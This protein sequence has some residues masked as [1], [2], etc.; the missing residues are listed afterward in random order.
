MRRSKLR[1]LA[2]VSAA[3]ASLSLWPAAP[4]RAGSAVFDGDAAAIGTQGDNVTFSSAANWTTDGNVDTAPNLTTTAPFD[5]LTFGGGTAGAIIDLGGN[6]GANS[7][8]FNR[9]YTLGLAATGN[10]LSLST[11]NVSVTGGNTGTINAI[12]AGTAGLNLSGGG[13]LTLNRSTGNTFTGNI[14][15]DGAGTTLAYVGTGGSADPTALGAGAKS[16]TLT[17]GGTL[18]IIGAA[19]DPN[20]TNTKTFVIGSGGGTIDT[21]FNLTFNDSTQFSGSGNLTKTGAGQ[22]TIINQAY[23]YTGSAIAVNAGTLQAGGSNAGALGGGNVAITVSNGATFDVTAALSGTKTVTVGGTGV[24]NNGALIN[25][26]AANTGTV[27]AVTMTAD[28]TMGGAGTLSVGQVTGGFNLT[29]IGGGLM[30]LNNASNTLGANTAVN[31]GTLRDATGT[32]LPSNTNLNLT[33]SIFETRGTFNRALGTNAGEVQIN[34]GTAAGI[35][36]N[37]APLTVN[38]GGAAAELAWGVGL[39]N[40]GTFVLNGSVANNT[41]TLQNPIDLNAGAANVTRTISSGANTAT[42]SALVRNSSTTNTAGLIKTGAGTLVLSNATNTYDGGTTINGGTLS[43]PS[44]PDGATSPIGSGN[45]TFTGG[46]TGSTFTYSGSTSIITNRTFTIGANNATIS[47]SNASGGLE[48]PSSLNGGTSNVFTKAGAGTLTLSGTSDNASL[49]LNATGGLTLLNKTGVNGMRA[50]AGISGIATGATVRLVPGS[51]DDQIYGG[52]ATST[53]GLVNLSGGTLDLNTKSESVARLSGYGAITNDG[54]NGTTS[55]LTVGETNATGASYAGNINDGASGGKT[56]LVKI[57]TGT[58]VLAGAGNFSGGT[59]VNGGV[60]RATTNTALGAGPVTLN[61]GTT[62]SLAATPVSG[63]GGNGAGYTLNGGPT[64]ASDVLTITTAAGSQARSIYNNNRVDVRGFNASFR[65]DNGT[66]GG[67]AD[68][69][70]FIL[71]NQGLT[72]LGGSGGSKGYSN[73]APSLAV[74]FNIYQNDNTSVGSNGGLSNILGAQDTAPL[75]LLDLADI[76]VSYNGT[77]LT[78]TATNPN[79][80]T[81]T[82]TRSVA[83]NIP[84]IV[85]S[86]S[87]YVGFTGG[88]GGTNAM[89]TISS[90]VYTPTATLNF[91]NAVQVSSGATAGLEVS[92]ASAATVGPVSVG[93]GSTLNITN[94]GA[95]TNAPYTVTAGATTLATGAIINL[96]S[97]GTGAGTLAVSN[98]SGVG[99]INGALTVSGTAAPG[100]SVGTINTGSLSLLSGSTYSVELDPTNSGGNGIAD[101]LAVT[102]NVNVTDS[103]LSISLLSTPTDGQQFTII[104]NDGSGDAVIGTFANAGSLTVGGFNFTVNTAGGDGNDV[105]LTA[106][107]VPEPAAI[108]VLGVAT[109]GLLSRRRRR[110]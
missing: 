13:T 32:S 30:I 44:L 24:G 87:A 22:L 83:V 8:A 65:Y 36:A 110:Q 52:N 67:G 102:G 28:T 62:L 92:G 23:S 10:T 1:G 50:V 9:N 94:A 106:T 5:D 74:V 14:T 25:S 43:V 64:V 109:V 85:G 4:V 59:T 90:F 58:Q 45:I 93:A 7:L 86:N 31:G 27:G 19:S 54:A 40:P 26:V 42:I 78:F 75:T 100:N 37:G 95:T 107:S 34:G 72:A 79:D 21:P 66:N 69:I 103:L 68:G 49:I 70:T 2:A 47:V 29:K 48:I 51:S 46:T 39:F 41:L 33:G 82:I 35:S 57:G 71:Q 38:I 80:T 15:V 88:T 81:Q 55:V 63:F 3:V 17:N 18:S 16:I 89:Q 53:A 84:S 101:L 12:I 98:L 105:V 96:A 20:S 73:I 104:N 99:T 61:N 11:A 77:T 76:N 91:A 56:A 108:G 60:L 6:R 97:N